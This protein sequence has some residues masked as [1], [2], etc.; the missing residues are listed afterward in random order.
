MLTLYSMPSSGNSYKV[1]LLLAKLGIPYRHIA[2]EYGSG[3]T[4]SPAFLAR[5]PNGRVPLLELP[6]GR[7]L[8]ESNAILLWLA[9]GSRFLPDDRYALALVHQW[10]FWEQ[11]THEATVAVRAAV[12]GYAHRAHQ[13]TPERLAELLEGGNRALGVMEVQLGKTPYLAGD[14]LSV[15]DVCLYGY[16]HSAGERGGF[17]MARFP[18]IGAWLERVAADRPHVGLDDI[19]G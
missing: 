18:A 16:T 8:S 11:N 19:P 7:L 5:N 9:E 3:V 14:R 1:R 13:R 15:A 4:T 2:A 12:L 17:D 6:D 10:M